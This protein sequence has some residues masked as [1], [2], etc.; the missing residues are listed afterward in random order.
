MIAGI[1]L[2]ALAVGGEPVDLSGLHKPTYYPYPMATS[3]SGRMTASLDTPIARSFA[4]SNSQ[5][6]DQAQVQERFR[7]VGESN[8]PL[9]GAQ[10]SGRDGANNLIQGIT[11]DNGD[12]TITGA[13]GIWQFLVYVSGYFSDAMICP[14]T[15]STSKVLK[16]QPSGAL[17]E[18]DISGHINKKDILPTTKITMPAFC[19][20]TTQQGSDLT[21]DPSTY[22]GDEG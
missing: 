6:I 13:P 17:E 1:E 12:V 11:D 21:T 2:T 5:E 4:P 22:T 3:P 19:S 7:F 10:F 14:F 16:L 9:S 15:Y 20:N 8:Q 18:L